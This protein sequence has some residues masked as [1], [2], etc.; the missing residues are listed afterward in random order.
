MVIKL[1]CIQN[2]IKT[3]GNYNENITFTYADETKQNI[4]AR[5]K[6]DD[7]VIDTTLKFLRV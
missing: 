3:V 2:K 5:S 7:D 1:L 4:K 6:D